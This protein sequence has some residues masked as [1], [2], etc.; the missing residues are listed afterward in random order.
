MSRHFAQSLLIC[1]LLLSFA[2]LADQPPQPLQPLI[3]KAQPRATLRLPPGR[4]LGPVVIDKPLTLDGA[5]QA[6]IDGAGVGT[7]VTIESDGVRL[8]NLRITGSGDR[9]NQLDAGIRVSGR[10][11]VIKDNILEDV[12]FGIVLHQSE[13]AVVRRNRIRSKPLALPQRGDGIRLWYSR[14]NQ[15]LDNRVEDARDVIVMDSRENLLSGNRVERGRYSLHVVNSEGTRIIGNQFV[16]NEA[17]VFA[18][19]AN[20]LE[21]RD[22]LVAEIHDVTGVG[23]GLK[24]SSSATIEGNR[25]FNVTVGIAL[26]LSPEDHELPNRVSRNLLAYNMVGIQFLSDRGGNHLSGNRLFGNYLPVAVRNGGGAMKNRWRGNGWS[27][28]AGFDRDRDGT[29]DTP[30]ELYAYADQLWLDYPN[31]QFFIASPT[32]T[33]LDFLERLAPFTEPRLLVRDSAPRLRDDVAE[34]VAREGRGST[35]SLC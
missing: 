16:D 21:I 32:F 30:Y 26:D 31:T 1:C 12:L 9:H 8:T 14:S 24:E 7:V 33:L 2:S 15:V 35:C 10:F 29:G 34:S 25:V 4:Y 23:I 17:G 22:N 6:T 11:N 28:Y 5:G 3:D 18:L 27:D 20:G 13:N 19:K